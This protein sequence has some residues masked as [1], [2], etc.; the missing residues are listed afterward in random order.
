MAER[1]GRTVVYVSSCDSHRVDVMGLDGA[2]GALA[3]I[4][5]IALPGEPGSATPMA[6]NP[7]RDR[8][9]V[10]LR[11]KPYTVACYG[12]DPASG[13]LSHRG[14]GPLADSMAYLAVDASGRFLLTASYPGHKIAVNPIDAEGVVGPIRQVIGELPNAHAIITDPANRF[15]LVA[16]LGSDTV[17]QYRFD[18]STGALT[19]NNP[20]ALRF[21]DKVGPRHLVFH[22]D[23]RHVYLLSELS[24]EVYALDYAA[25]AGAL[26]IKQ[27]LSYK[28]P[29]YAYNGGNWAGAD[30]RMTPDGRF[31][32]ACERTTSTITAFRIAPDGSMSFVEQV[33]TETQPRTMAIDPSGRYLLAAGQMSHHV[34]VYAVGADTGRLTTLGRYS[35]GRN[36]NW[37]EAVALP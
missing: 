19:A 6:V 2:T 10:G 23:G 1:S 25:E 32:Y 33:P 17:R 22:P 31:V 7:A 35:T 28:T 12:I 15:A 13:R 18:V 16:S 26:A 29:G 20:E 27:A 3:P 24:V 37:I 8:L 5:T 14:N 11:A 4:E 36:P 30:I 34:M 9:Y 21:A